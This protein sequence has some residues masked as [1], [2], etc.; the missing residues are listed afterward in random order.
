MLEKPEGE[1]TKADL[2]KVT[3]QPRTPSTYHV[4]GLEKLTQLKA[5]QRQPTDR[6]K[7]ARDYAVTISRN[8]HDPPKLNLN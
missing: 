7:E 3:F 6:S 4:K 8:N 5:L 2:E 1:L